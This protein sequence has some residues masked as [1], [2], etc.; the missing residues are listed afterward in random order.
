VNGLS[1]LVSSTQQMQQQVQVATTLDSVKAAV[2][3]PNNLIPTP[4]PTQQ[5][6]SNN[7]SLP[8][9]AIN[10][11]P[12]DFGSTDTKLQP[13]PSPSSPSISN[14]SQE[15]LLKQLREYGKQREKL[16]TGKEVTQLDN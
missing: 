13:A 6:M 4:A 12:F 9:Y 3:K 8:V 2:S 16:E 1:G 14:S 15:N 5:A 7:K 11:L 10:P